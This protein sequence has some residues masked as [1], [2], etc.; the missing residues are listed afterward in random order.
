[1][2]IEPFPPPTRDQCA[3]NIRLLVTRGPAALSGLHQPLARARWQSISCIDSFVVGVDPVL[4]S[5]SQQAEP[6]ILR[7]LY[8]Q[9]EMSGNAMFIVF[10]GGPVSQA[11]CSPVRSRSPAPQIQIACDQE[12]PHHLHMRGSTGNIASRS[13]AGYIVISKDSQTVDRTACERSAR[14]SE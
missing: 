9:N 4:H 11:E 10:N 8:C 2:A 3:G 13:A 12:P 6:Q 1:M 7:N 5:H 14:P